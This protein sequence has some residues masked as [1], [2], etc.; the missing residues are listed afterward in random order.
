ME[1]RCVVSQLQPMKMLRITI[2]YGDI[3]IPM[4]GKPFLDASSKRVVKAN[5]KIGEKMMGKI[6]SQ[7]ARAMQEIAE[8]AE[9]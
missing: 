1:R 2:Q 6:G 3:V 5:G 7:L 4:E 8:E 9:G